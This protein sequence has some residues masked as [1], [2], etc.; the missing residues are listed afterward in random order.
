M[1]RSVGMA[2]MALPVRCI[3]PM[4]L[5]HEMKIEMQNCGAV[6]NMVV[7]LSSNMDIVSSTRNE[8]A[9]NMAEI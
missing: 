9:R 3:V 7:K 2:T 5:R 1:G 6:V 4:V 8:Y